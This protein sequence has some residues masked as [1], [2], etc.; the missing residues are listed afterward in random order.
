MDSTHIQIYVA[1]IGEEEPCCSKDLRKRFKLVRRYIEMHNL[2][3]SDQTVGYRVDLDEQILVQY[4]ETKQDPVSFGLREAEVSSRKALRIGEEMYTQGVTTR[5]ELLELPEGEL[6]G[7]TQDP[8]VTKEIMD[9]QNK[10]R[11]L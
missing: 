7:F 6:S 1:L 5:L 10:N 9:W 2:D 11:S 8:K 4:L 3:S